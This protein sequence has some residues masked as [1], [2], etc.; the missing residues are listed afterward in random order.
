VL[1]NGKIH[2][3]TGKGGVGKSTLSVAFAREL[4]IQGYKTLWLEFSQAP[5]YKNISEK[6]LGFKPIQLEPNLDIASWNGEDCLQEFVKH[7]VKLRLI[8]ETFYRS[9]AISALIKAAPAL[10]EIAFL[11]YLTSHLRN[12]E[13]CL[14]YDQIVV[15]AP[16]T[17]HFLACLKVP[18]ALLD[19]SSIGPM[20]FHCN[21]ILKVLRDHESTQI[22]SIFLAEPL[23]V[24]EHE[25]LQK[26][27]EKL[28]LKSR[29]WLNKGIEDLIVNELQSL[30]PLNQKSSF[31][32]KL[33]NLKLQ[34]DQ[35]VQNL[36]SQQ[37][38]MTSDTDVT[39]LKLEMSKI[40][41]G[42]I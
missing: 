38:V 42:L 34:Q 17:G 30:E 24:I 7:S 23:V 5:T 1:K 18:E 22:Y 29:P 37:L 33:L 15:D 16:S 40:I 6:S 8:Y 11:G 31:A 28:G 39:G 12:V 27:L 41:K 26:E 25:Y 36:D 3:F 4:A 19:I 32:D 35:I 21:G 9:K 13:P 2:F 20:G 14:R 10:R